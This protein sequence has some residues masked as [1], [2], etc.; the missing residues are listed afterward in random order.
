MSGTASAVS[1]RTRLGWICVC[2]QGF[3]VFLVYMV[4]GNKKCV[5]E[6]RSLI[7]QGLICDYLTFGQTRRPLPELNQWVPA[8]ALQRQH[9]QR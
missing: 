5:F 8:A 1:V 3:F 7:N 4:G 2:E 6:V 9:L